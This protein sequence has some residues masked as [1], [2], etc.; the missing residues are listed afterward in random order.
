M[1]S[2]MLTADM[3]LNVK[4]TPAFTL[5]ASR[6]D[7]AARCRHAAQTGRRQ[8]RVTSGGL[9]VLVTAHV[10]DGAQVTRVAVGRRGAGV[11]KRVERVSR[12]ALQPVAWP[13]PLPGI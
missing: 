10:Q 7:L 5:G 12:D 13:T 11:P 6:N 2:S 3:Q 8:D 9:R 1:V 4:I